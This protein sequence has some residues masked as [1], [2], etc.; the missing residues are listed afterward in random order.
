MEQS[1]MEVNKQEMTNSRVKEAK[2]EIETENHQ[3]GDQDGDQEGGTRGFSPTNQCQNCGRHGE[4]V[5]GCPNK[6]WRQRPGDS[7]EERY[8][9]CRSVIDVEKD[10]TTPSSQRTCGACLHVGHWMKCCPHEK[11]NF[12]IMNDKKGDMPIVEDKP[13]C[14]HQLCMMGGKWLPLIPEDSSDD[15]DE[16]ISR[17]YCETLEEPANIE[18]IM[19]RSTKRWTAKCLAFHESRR[20]RSL[21]IPEENEK[22]EENDLKEEDEVM[23]VEIETHPEFLSE[24]TSGENHKKGE[25]EDWHGGLRLAQL[26]ESL[27]PT[28]RNRMEVV[29]KEHFKKVTLQGGKEFFIGNT[30]EKEQEE[31]IQELLLEYKDVFA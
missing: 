2:A 23:Q 1:I 24:P 22:D 10:E 16:K 20:Q 26:E 28:L 25:V 11:K 31:S 17:H 27:D 6:S 21:E 19:E 7:A 8:Q 14:Q 30:F 12:W 3:D 4:E 9:L 13:T 18:E 29:K 5:D 15:E